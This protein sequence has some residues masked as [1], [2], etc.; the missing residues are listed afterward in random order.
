MSWH[1]CCLQPCSCALLSIDISSDLSL[2][3]HISSICTDRLLLPTL[4]TLTYLAVVGLR[5]VVFTRLRR[6]EITNWL[7]QHGSC[8]RTKNSNRQITTCVECSCMH[9]VTSILKFSLRPRS[10]T[11]Q[12]QT[13]PVWRPDQ[14]LQA[15]SDSSLSERTQT[16]KPV[17]LLRSS[18]RCWHLEAS[19]FCQPSTS[20]STALLDLHLQLS[21]FQLPTSESETL[22]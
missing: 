4:W 22:S 21:P 18:R 2:D 3:H 15:G 8:W 1:R 14:V 17:G 10:D 20:R 16:T 7:L 12:R 5:L 9:H 19:A 13:S 11:A 6:C